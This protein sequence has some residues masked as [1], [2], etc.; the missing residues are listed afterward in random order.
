LRP[1][2]YLHYKINRKMATIKLNSHYGNTKIKIIIYTCLFSFMFFTA[3]HVIRAQQQQWASQYIFWKFDQNAKDI[4]NIDQKIWV[5]R[6]NNKSYWPLV[7]SW[8]DGNGVGGYMGLQQGTSGSNQNVRF[9]LWNAI[10]ADVSNAK[11]ATARKFGGEGIG[12]T[13]ELP[14]TINPNKFYRYRL[15]RLNEDA[16]GRWWG[17]W[18]IEA[19]SN[20]NL[21]EHPLGKIKVPKKYN[22]VDVNSISNFVEYYGDRMDE[23]RKVPPSV[24]GFTPPYVNYKGNGNYTAYSTYNYSNKAEGNRCVN[25]NESNGALISVRKYNFGFVQG[26]MAFLGAPSDMPNRVPYDLPNN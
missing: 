15:W 9:S 26:V 14:F 8:E 19:D 13:C 23:C 17:A 12:Y 2:K 18:I 22:H 20:G 10:D 5:Q 16:E 1:R 11:G 21:I 4:M 25:G 7:W 3:T 6:S 24:I